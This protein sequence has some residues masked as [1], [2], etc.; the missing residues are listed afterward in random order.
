MLPN[1]PVIATIVI[2][3][4]RNSISSGATPVG[5]SSDIFVVVVVVQILFCIHSNFKLSLS[6]WKRP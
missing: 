1:V 6:F 2:S 3:T 4:F 5:D